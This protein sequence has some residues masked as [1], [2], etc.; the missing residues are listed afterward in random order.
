MRDAG[1]GMRDAGCEMRDESRSTV[2]KLPDEADDH[3]DDAVTEID[4]QANV[5]DRHELEPREHSEMAVQFGV[6]SQCDLQAT[7][8]LRRRAQGITFCNVG[9]YGKRSPTDLIE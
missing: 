1:C 4:D 6:G 8:E 7:E 9:R 2:A 5:I 3:R